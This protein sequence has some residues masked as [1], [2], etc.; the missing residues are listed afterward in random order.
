MWNK[1]AVLGNHTTRFFST[2][3]RGSMKMND[4]QRKL[5]QGMIDSIQCYIDQET[6]DF[7]SV[8]GELEGAL[9]ASDIADKDLVSQWYDFWTPLEIRRAVGEEINR[10]KAVEE[11]T[12]MKN[13]LLKAKSY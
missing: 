7:Y 13:F 8:V 11:L 4:H 2:K 9:D 3:T 12:E 6:D 10:V 1:C 5:W